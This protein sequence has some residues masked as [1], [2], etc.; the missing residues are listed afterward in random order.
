M[1]DQAGLRKAVVQVLRQTYARFLAERE[2]RR[3]EL[4]TDAEV[5]LLI[6]PVQGAFNHDLRALYAIL[7]Q[8]QAQGAEH[9]RQAVHQTALLPDEHERMDLAVREAEERAKDGLPP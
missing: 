4:L 7:A 1:T 5:S 2:G 6:A 8:A 9:V 3:A